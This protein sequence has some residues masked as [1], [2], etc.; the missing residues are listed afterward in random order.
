MVNVNPDVWGLDAD[1]FEPERWLSD[2]LPRERLPTGPFS[3]TFTFLDGP[4]HCIGWR[5]G[6][7]SS[8]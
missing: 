6:M 2:A 1:S 7:M 3:N 5:L 8:S 4:R